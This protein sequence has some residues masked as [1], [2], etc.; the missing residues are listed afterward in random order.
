MYKPRSECQIAYFTHP[1]NSTFTRTHAHT[2][3]QQS[4]YFVTSFPRNYII[5]FALMTGDILVSRY[6][7]ELM[8]IFILI[9]GVSDQST[10]S[11][12]LNWPSLCLCFSFPSFF[13]FKHFAYGSLAWETIR[14]LSSGAYGIVT[15]ISLLIFYCPGSCRGK[16]A[17]YLAT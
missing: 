15:F 5:L 10:F 13:F 16:V 4:N 7:Y 6:D 14:I 3:T 1:P 8:F 17:S 12:L 2:H 11:F 9:D